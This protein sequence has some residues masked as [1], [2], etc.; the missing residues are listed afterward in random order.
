VAFKMFVILGFKIM[1]SFG[2]IL[3]VFVAKIVAGIVEA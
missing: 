3:V 1:L 2:P